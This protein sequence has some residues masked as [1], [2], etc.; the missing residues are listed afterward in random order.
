MLITL[1]KSKIHRA[2]IT[3]CDIAYDGS[4]GLD[5]EFM[6]LAGLREYE[7]VLV[8]NISNGQRF[9]TYV[10]KAEKN[11]RTVSLNGAAARLGELGDKVIILAYGRMK[12]KKAETFKP[13]IVI[14]DD[15]NNP[16]LKK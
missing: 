1:L 9:E 2:S 8:A 10:I 16:K 6:K 15:N 12:E 7:K 13:K 5:E 14:M 3:Q 4:I 11:S